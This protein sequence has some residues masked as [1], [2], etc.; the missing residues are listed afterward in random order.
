ML[1]MFSNHIPHLV[2]GTL[3]LPDRE[4]AKIHSNQANP[5]I[6]GPNQSLTSP[7]GMHNSLPLLNPNYSIANVHPVVTLRGVAGTRWCRL[8]P[9]YTCRALSSDESTMGQLGRKNTGSLTSVF[10]I[11][12]ADE[13][14][15][16]K[17]QLVIIPETLLVEARGPPASM[18]WTQAVTGSTFAWP[19]RNS[20][21]IRIPEWSGT[22][23][24]TTAKIFRK[25]TCAV[26]RRFLLA[27]ANPAQ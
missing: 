6:R 14:A 3:L 17:R 20:R 8:P 11:V 27:G 10:S 12:D 4:S 5:I 13:S 16:R 25:T 23:R 2:V 22:K 15:S 26:E 9:R 1:V 7:T 18:P 24:A 21:T 19:R